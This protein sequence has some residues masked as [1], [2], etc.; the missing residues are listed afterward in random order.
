MIGAFSPAESWVLVGACLVAA[1]ALYIAIVGGG[2][3]EKMK[4]DARTSAWLESVDEKT[5]VRILPGVY[6]WQAGDDFGDRDW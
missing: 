2:R 4:Q 6:D 3:H 5:W 1:I